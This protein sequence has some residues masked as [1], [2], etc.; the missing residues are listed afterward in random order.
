MKWIILQ[1]FKEGPLWNGNSQQGLIRSLYKQNPL[2]NVV[3]MVNGMYHR[4]GIWL[5]PYRI[6]LLFQVWLKQCSPD[7]LNYFYIMTQF[8]N[9]FSSIFQILNDALQPHNQWMFLSCLGYIGSSYAPTIFTVFGNSVTSYISNVQFPDFEPLFPPLL[10][11]SPP[12]PSPSLMM[13]SPID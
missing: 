9:F 7:N 11:F 1:E 10:R 13:P 6:M 5:L 8:W 12:S 3:L 2:L 4:K